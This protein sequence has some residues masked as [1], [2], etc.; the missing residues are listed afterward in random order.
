MK[1]EYAAMVRRGWP[2]DGAIDEAVVIKTGSTLKN[3][4]WVSK[5]TDGTVMLSGASASNTVGLVIAGNDD[6]ASAA[7]SNKA[8]VLWSGFIVDISNHDVVGPPAYAPGS[9]LTAKNGK[10][11]LGNGTTDPVV[12]T[13]LEVVALSDSE[14]AH[15]K[16]L[17]K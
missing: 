13:V 16:V 3:G 10:L 4:D 1:M 15:L 17:V 5:H 6:S 9:P 2:N 11:T 8:V 14:T 7:N 12:G